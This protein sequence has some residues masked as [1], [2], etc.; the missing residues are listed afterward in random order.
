MDHQNEK[1]TA[2]VTDKTP[3]KTK[4][5]DKAKAS[6]PW[7]KDRG[8]SAAEGFAGGAILRDAEQRIQKVRR[9]EGKPIDKILAIG[10]IPL[11]LWCWIRA[12][13]RK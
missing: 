3:I 2:P 11:G 9:G 8:R 1:S 5:R 13:F 12:I 7:V 10:E 6:M 4:I